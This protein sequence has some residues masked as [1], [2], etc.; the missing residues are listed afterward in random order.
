MG[1]D[2]YLHLLISQ[3]HI[4]VQAPWWTLALLRICPVNLKMFFS[5]PHTVMAASL[6]TVLHVNFSSFSEVW[7]YT[8]KCTLNP[9]DMGIPGRAS[10]ACVHVCVCACAF[11]I[12]S[13][14]QRWQLGRML[15]G[16]SRWLMNGQFLWPGGNCVKSDQYWF[17]LDTRQ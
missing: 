13:V 7:G 9:G 4:M 8:H 3:T 2:L 17:M 15:P 11:V 16:E 5:W 6:C 14:L 1:Q 10:M 12:S